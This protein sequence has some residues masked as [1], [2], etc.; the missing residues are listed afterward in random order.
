PSCR[1]Q[2]SG[3]E[4]RL[5]STGKSVKRSSASARRGRN[6]RLGPALGALVAPIPGGT[7]PALDRGRTRAGV[8]HCDLAGGRVAPLGARMHVDAGVHANGVARAGLDAE[9]AD[10]ALQLVDL[11]ENRELLVGIGALA[12]V[13]RDAMRRAHRRTEHARD[14]AD[15]AVLALH[16]AV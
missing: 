15:R 9:T 2:Q 14:A 6:V 7:E 8:P 16:Q 3:F 12:R 11:E 4:S 13:D 1:T 5:M 10:D